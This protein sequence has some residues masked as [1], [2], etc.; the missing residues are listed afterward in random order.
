MPVRAR[1]AARTGGHPGALPQSGTQDRGPP[2]AVSVRVTGAFSPSNPNPVINFGLQV[3]RVGFSADI[4]TVR[5]GSGWYLGLDSTAVAGAPTPAPVTTTS[6][7]LR[8]AAPPTPTPSP[9]PTPLPTSTL[10]VATFTADLATGSNLPAPG[11]IHFGRYMLAYEGS[12]ALLGGCIYGSVGDRCFWGV[13]RPAGFVTVAATASAQGE[14]GIML[15]ALRDD[16]FD[17][18]ALNSAALASINPRTGQFQVVIVSHAGAAAVDS[19]GGQVV[20]SGPCDCI[21]RSAANTVE[22]G[23]SG[24]ELVLKINGVPAVRVADTQG[25]RG[26]GYGVFWVDGPPDSLTSID[27]TYFA[28]K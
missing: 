2:Q 27:P 4:H 26:S 1:R 11:R 21:N 17:A 3:A 10:E 25:L 28:A 6:T 19:G 22:F 18:Q 8:T 24:T 9:T 16:W 13:N 12:H 23:A 20:A 14:W 7:P 15:R 5:D